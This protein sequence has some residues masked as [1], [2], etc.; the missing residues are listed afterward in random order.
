MQS[1]LQLFFNV[2]IAMLLSI[3]TLIYFDDGTLLLGTLLLAIIATKVKE[4]TLTLSIFAGVG[5]AL[6]IAPSVGVEMNTILNLQNGFLVQTISSLLFFVAFYMSKISII[7]R[8]TKAGSIG[9]VASSMIS[10]AAGGISSSLLWQ[11]YLTLFN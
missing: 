6:S 5:F 3:A 9:V 1:N 8:I 11:G 2:F 7:G 10:G 4:R